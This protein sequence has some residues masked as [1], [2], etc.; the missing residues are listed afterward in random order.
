MLKKIT[1]LVLFA[2]TIILGHATLS[3][4]WGFWAHEH[5]NR[6]AVFTLPEELKKFY[7]KNIDFVT[8]HSVDADKRRSSDKKEGV[9]HYIDADY[10]GSSPFDSIPK[11]WD[12]AIAKF[13]QDTLEAYGINPWYIAIVTKRLTQAFVNG[14]KDSILILSAD[15]GHYVA[16]AHVPLHATMNYDGQLTNQKGIHSFWESRLPELFGANYNYYVSNAKYIKYPLTESWMII[17]SRFSTLDTV[18]LLERQ[19]NEQFPKDEK[20]TA[21]KKGDKVYY[22]YSEEYSRQ[23]HNMLNHMVERRMRSA[24]FEV[25]SFWYTAWVNAG[26]PDL[27][28]IDKTILDEE[29]KQ[30]LD[31]EEALWKTGKI[32]IKGK[33]N[34]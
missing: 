4:G 28:K 19:L 30:K 3:Y 11:S 29:T 12:K 22:D 18:L 23:Y 21:I 32:T 2:G 27:N 15:L 34:N 13:S 26:R 7:K 1:L 10:Y 17:R 24:I 16:D 20:Y 8:I 5:I 31:K 14:D 6:S 33:F 25:G 9:R